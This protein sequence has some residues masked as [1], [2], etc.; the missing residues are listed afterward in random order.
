MNP[1]QPL[2]TEQPPD[3]T[4]V[5]LTKDPDDPS[6]AIWRGVFGDRAR[7]AGWTHWRPHEAES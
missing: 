1:W 7:G 6:R 4:I 2:T 3:N 5:Q